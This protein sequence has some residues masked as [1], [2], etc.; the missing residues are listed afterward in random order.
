MRAAMLMTLTYQNF[1]LLQVDKT[2]AVVTT[3]NGNP[4]IM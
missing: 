3:V 4:F 2:A 1:T